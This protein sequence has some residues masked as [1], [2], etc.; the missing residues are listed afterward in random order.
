MRRYEN[1][2]INKLK[3]YENNARTHSEKQVEKIAK[4]IQE[5][6]FINPVL[7][8][9]N[10][11]I[12]A[13]H[14]RIEGAK[15]LGMKEV[16]CLFIED[17]SEEQK[18]AYIIADNKLA[19]DAGWDYDLLKIELEE[20][21][22][23]DFD[24]TLTGFDLDLDFPDNFET[25]QGSAEKT[26]E[27]V[28]GILNLDKAQFEDVEGK[29]DIPKLEPIY[30]NEI[31]EI[32]EW[33]GFNYVLSDTEPKGKGVHFFV[34]D[35]QFIRLW[36]NPDKYIDKLL[37]YEAVLTPDFSPYA[38]MPMATQIFNHYRKH[39]VG[40]YLQE[41]GVKIIPTIR[42]ST[43]DRS[44]EWYLDGEPKGGVVCISSMWTSEETSREKF[45]VEY[46][47]MRK[48]L[49]PTK[50]YVYGKQIEGLKGNIEYI[51]TFSETRWRK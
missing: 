3:P 24:I 35:Y 49:K 43:D 10:Y 16:P 30:E 45:M 7:I 23:L 42:A 39:W 36:N 4:S 28:E 13:G 27:R 37:Q 50:I 44:L 34:D 32:K 25:E 9:S 38:D 15:K 40:A 26:Q 31:G 22:N 21:D 14:G 18:R 51:K 33:I 8:D 6:G 47:T 20:L 5:F 29:Y 19:L 1:V 46:E 41:R 2:P 11:G 12:I 48:K 17:L